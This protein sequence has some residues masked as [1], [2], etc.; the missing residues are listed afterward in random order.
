MISACPSFTADVNGT[1]TRLIDRG[2]ALTHLRIR[3]RTLE[4]LFLELTGTEL[5]A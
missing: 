4:D 3:E 2:I 1:I 5:R